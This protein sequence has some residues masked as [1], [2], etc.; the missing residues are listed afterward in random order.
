MDVDSYL[1]YEG[2]VEL[3][4]KQA[5]TALVRIPNWVDPDQLKSY[6]NDKLVQPAQSGRYLVFDGLPKG[7]TLRLQFPNPESRDEYT[8]HGQ[9]YQVTFRGSTIVDIQPRPDPQLLNWFRGSPTFQLYQRS[10]FQANQAP[11]RR[12]QRFA[13]E[14]VLP[15][16]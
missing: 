10:P 8:I 9:R 3:H 1:P 15:L 16:Q 4:N 13:P 12:V 11:L 14:K 2:K 6:I 5:K 7:A